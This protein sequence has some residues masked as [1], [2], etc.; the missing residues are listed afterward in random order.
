MEPGTLVGCHQ[1][2]VSFAVLDVKSTTVDDPSCYANH[3]SA[4][5]K[6]STLLNTLSLDNL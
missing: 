6:K 4:L 3:F 2:G 5:G 1:E